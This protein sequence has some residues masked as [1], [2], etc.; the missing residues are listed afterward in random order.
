MS[1]LES[2]PL[3]ATC[4]GR[5]GESG[6]CTCIRCLWDSLK[7]D[8]RG[9][10]QIPHVDDE[11][12][13]QP[14]SDNA[15]EHVSTCT[16]GESVSVSES[17]SEDEVGRNTNNSRSDSSDRGANDDANGVMIL[18]RAL[19]HPGSHQKAWQQH[20]VVALQ[21]LYTIR[22]PSWNFI[23]YVLCRTAR[24]VERRYKRGF[25]PRVDR[26]AS[27]K[28][29]GR[30]TRG[31]DRLLINLITMHNSSCYRSDDSRHPTW[32][33]MCMHLDR[34]P[35]SIRQRWL[36]LEKHQRCATR[37]VMETVPH[38]QSVTRSTPVHAW[39]KSD[40]ARLM[41]LHAVHGS[42]WKDTSR[43]MGLSRSS[44]RNRWLRLQQMWLVGV[45][46]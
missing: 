5:S 22:G 45:G 25:G 14:P 9:I 17:E 12:P 38:Q 27:A 4:I 29:A 6:V 13:L 19:S 32:S 28:I 37:D 16:I 23:G 2:C 42:S 46:K 20:E 11:P 26:S 31:E 24:S 1:E 7:D 44:V 15:R 18:K 36:R 10:W 3:D 21:A 35:T 41:A 30:W 43:V 34:S 39:T 8:A 33:S 40:D